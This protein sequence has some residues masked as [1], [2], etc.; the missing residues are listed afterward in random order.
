MEF[1]SLSPRHRSAEVFGLLCEVLSPKS[2]S[3]HATQAFADPQRTAA[4]LALAEEE[5]VSATFHEAV[6]GRFSEI[7]PKADRAVLATHYE[8]NR[9]R[10][11][12]LRVALLELGE[13]G[14]SSGIR[15]AA[16]KGAAWLLEDAAG[17][18]TWRQ[19]VDIDVLVHPEQFE[20]VPR[21]L[22]RMGYTPASAAKR[23][24]HNFHH[25]PYRHPRIAVT[26]EVHRHVGW[27]HHLLPYETLLASSRPVTPCLV[28]P[29]P[30][31]RAFHAIIHWQIQDHGGSRGTLPLKEVVEVARFLAR[32]D[33][34]WATLSAH[35]TR[36]GALEACQRAIA[37]AATLL[38][39]PVPPELT[40]EAAAQRWVARSVAHRAS[41][42]RTWLATQ[43]WRAG[44][45][46]RCEKLSYRCALRGFKPSMI[47]LMVWGARIIK[48][49]LLAVRATGIAARALAW[50]GSRGLAR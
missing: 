11:S 3:R 43:M 36:V 22:R 23:F 20:V 6:A 2:R 14:A 41:P 25:A 7:L 4:T 19:M 46:W 29:S 8:A 35:A 37:A 16:L 27:R 24:K 34:D 47:V 1:G 12:A 15:F 45:L 18:A 40:P 32:S 10:N 31:T 21:L 30:W 5:H 39:A 48:L 9:R 17:C 13:A 49:P 44:T 42:L 28:L 26:L 38:N 50:A 33:V